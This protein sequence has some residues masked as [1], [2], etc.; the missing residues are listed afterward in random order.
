MDNSITLNLKQPKYRIGDRVKQGLI[1]GLENY[2]HDSY[3]CQKYGAG[4]RY[5]MLPDKAE[6]DLNHYFEP[7]ITLLSPQQLKTQIEAEINQCQQQLEILQTELAIAANSIIPST[8]FVVKSH[9][10][11]G[12][13][14]NLSNKT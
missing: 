2:P 1:I 8:T 5:T 3:L 7:E 11:I 6:E 4:W 14:P 9:G 10:T 12:S 13:S